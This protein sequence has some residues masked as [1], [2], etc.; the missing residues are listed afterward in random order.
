MLKKGTVLNGKWE[1]VDHIASGG[2]ADV[3]RASQLNLERDV[4]VKVMSEAFLQSFE[5]DEA[6]IRVARDRFEREV[7]AMARV[8]HPNVLQVYDQGREVIQENGSERAVEYMVMEY[9]PGPDLRSTLNP[10]G[11]GY[12]EEA[13]KGWITDYFLPILDG[14]ETVHD[15]GVIHRDLKPANVILDGRTP[16]IADFGLAGGARWMRVTQTHHIAGTAPYQAPEPEPV[17]TGEDG[18]VLALVPAAEAVPLPE[19]QKGVVRTPGVPSFYLDETEVTNH[20]YV[21]FLN[22]VVAQIRVEEGAVRSENHLWLFLGEVKRGYEPI[23][24][25]DGNFSV[26]SPAFHSHP[27]VRV[28]AHGA[29]AYAAHYDRRLPTDAEWFL[30]AGDVR[31][32]EAKTQPNAEPHGMHHSGMMG[33]QVRFDIHHAC[34]FCSVK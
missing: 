29:A 5:G 30:A 15:M 6:E 27:V 4:A 25:K 28:T 9:I 13:V 22:R 8:R 33:E 12:D 7:K 26:S 24:Y 10:K 1:I 16:K 17:K 23:I 32:P 19:G 3:Y 14:L 18:S 11:L 20:Q 21:T 34:L 31:E 2:M